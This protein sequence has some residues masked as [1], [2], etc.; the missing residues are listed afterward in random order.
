MW[1]YLISAVEADLHRILTWVTILKIYIETIK[2][3]VF[4]ALNCNYI[5]WNASLDLNLLTK[6]LKKYLDSY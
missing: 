2:I 6:K 3:F 4:K 5:H 1:V